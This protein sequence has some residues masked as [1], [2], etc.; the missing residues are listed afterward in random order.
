MYCLGDV[1]QALSQK[2]EH[3]PYRNSKLTMLLKESLGGQSKTLMY[4]F[5]LQN[6]KNHNLNW[7]LDHE[8][9]S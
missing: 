4:I 1:I 5:Y 7:N 8:K 3:V 9:K 2:Q 6:Y